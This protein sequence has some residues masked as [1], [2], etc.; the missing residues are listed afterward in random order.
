MTQ[1]VHPWRGDPETV[2]TV[3]V[4]GMGKIGLPLAAQYAGHGWH[5]I[6]VD[7]QPRVVETL[8]RGRVHF[9]EEPTLAERIAEAHAA[10]RFRATT[11]H[12]E[13]TRDADVVVVIVPVML[14]DTKEPDYRYIDPATTAVAG[15]L[16]QGVLVLYETTLPVGDTR[17]R[18]GPM[19]E[20]ASGLAAGDPEAGFLLA[21]S[22]ERVY[23]GRV[24]HDLDTYPK[25]VGGVD[26]ASGA[27]AAAFYRSVVPAEVWQLSTAEAAEFAKLA[28][29]TYRDVNIALAN[30]FAEYAERM[31]VDILEVIRGSN[32]QPFSHIHQPGIGVGGH[33][34]PVYPH[35][36]ISRAP[37]LTLPALSRQVNDGQ[38]GAAVAALERE[39]GPLEG[40][41]VLVLGLT[42]R[43]DV[44]ELAYTRAIPL[45]DRLS[46]HGARVSA[47]DP[48][49]TDEEV[50]RTG[51]A[52]WH[53]G[54]RAPFRAVVVQ[55]G[56]RQFRSL[57]PAWF[58][59]LAVVFDGRNAVR[60]L[61]LPERV[62]YVGVGVPDPRAA[63]RVRR[64]A[65]AGSG[66]RR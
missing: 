54:D 38:V 36:L 41:P 10:G 12:A 31:G 14:S 22:P 40:T 35:F 44:K 47:Y 48:L 32:S 1:F 13:A 7:V 59:D 25:L 43:E 33:C 34:I 23:S 58:P 45:I 17:D 29:T 51:A 42:Y 37:E 19:L 21:F 64:T 56:A 30:Q 8:N 57:D 16:H 28:E 27:R 18:F 4:I 52:P 50:A 24:F 20:A 53:W 9:A 55:T 3:A 66:G 6:G 46:F 60:D 11:S 26:A 61:A 63:R 49:L 65:A 15:G 62:A 39:L 2:G 5:V